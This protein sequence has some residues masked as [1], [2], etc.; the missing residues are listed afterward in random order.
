M[1][2]FLCLAVT[3]PLEHTPESLTAAHHTWL[4]ETQFCCTYTFYEDDLTQRQDPYSPDR[5]DDLDPK[6]AGALLKNGTNVRFSRISPSGAN[7]SWQSLLDDKFEL[8][9]VPRWNSSYDT[10][11][12][13]S[14]SQ[15][16]YDR[17]RKFRAELEL[18]P[19]NPIGGAFDGLPGEPPGDAAWEVAKADAEF[20]HM[21]KEVT[22][23]RG[24]NHICEIEFWVE[25]TTPV[26]SRIVCTF[27][28]RLAELTTVTETRMF[29]WIDCGEFKVPGRIVRSLTEKTR[30]A[31]SNGFGF[32]ER[33]KLNIWHSQDLNGRVPTLSEFAFTVRPTTNVMGLRNIPAP[34]TVR[35]LSISDMQRDQA[36]NGKSEIIAK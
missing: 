25:P 24:S 1:Y 31:G 7:G 5:L 17:P 26:I 35:K 4:K 12:F 19:L 30:T 8:I 14:R 28:S 23:K 18:S 27:Q 13:T 32:R 3:I 10:A 36:L 6:A 16:P 21:R 22:S 2:L 20:V 11:T 9:Y 33:V 34:G 15:L 29:D